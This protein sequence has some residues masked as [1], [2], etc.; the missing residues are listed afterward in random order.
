M[1]YQNEIN[2][3]SEYY[4]LLM[5]NIRYLAVIVQKNIFCLDTMNTRWYTKYMSND[6]R[7]ACPFELLDFRQDYMFMIEQWKKYT[8]HQLTFPECCWMFSI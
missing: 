2:V 8:N 1:V 5:R 4:C 3:K 6:Q 7:S